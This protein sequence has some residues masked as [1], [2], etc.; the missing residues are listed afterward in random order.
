M[1]LCV[2]CWFSE[3]FL[4]LFSHFWSFTFFFA[5]FHCVLSGFKPHRYLGIFLATVFEDFGLSDLK[6][7]RE[8]GSLTCFFTPGLLD[9]LRL[10]D[11]KSNTKNSPRPTSKRPNIPVPT[12]AKANRDRRPECCFAKLQD[13]LKVLVKL[14][15]EEFC[16]FDCVSLL[17]N[18]VFSKPFRPK[19]YNFIGKN[20]QDITWR[21]TT[22]GA[23]C[24][25]T[26]PP[27]L[28]LFIVTLVAYRDFFKT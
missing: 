25:S 21:F 20:Q 28:K 1:S 13:T 8:L 2:F 5:G 17:R 22:K 15:N 16:L 23:K 7:G 4:V 6:P 27:S 12:S 26:N 3:V 10:G 18:W 14:Q 11:F 19:A 24:S 9:L